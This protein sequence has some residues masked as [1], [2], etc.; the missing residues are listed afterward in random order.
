MEK[1]KNLEELM[2]EV[3]RLRRFVLTNFSS[4]DKLHMEFHRKLSPL[5]ENYSIERLS[6]VNF[7][8]RAGG[9][10]TVEV[11]IIIPVYGKLSYTLGCL[12][13]LFDLGTKYSYEIIVVDDCSDDDSFSVLSSISGLRVIQNKVNLG[14]LKSCNLAADE[15]KGKYLVFLNNDT[16]VLSGWLDHLIDTFDNHSSVGLVGSQL[17]YPDGRL[18]EAGGILWDDASGWNYGRLDDPGKPEYSYVRDVDYCSGASIA[19]RKE[20]FLEMGGFDEI[21][22][23]AYFEDADLAFE[24]NKAGYRVLYQPMSKVIHFEGITSGRDLSSGVKSFQVVNKDKFYRKWRDRLKTHRKHGQLPFLERDRECKG[25]VLV[26][27]ALTPTPDRDAGSVTAFFYLKILVEMGYKVTFVPESLVSYGG[28]TSALQQI[29]VECLYQPSL[30]TVRTYLQNFGEHFDVVFLYRVWTARKF[31]DDVKQL[32]PNAKI[33]FDTVDLHYLREERKAELS[34]DLID[35][36]QA[37][38]T[39]AAEYFLMKNADATIVLSEE[40]KRIVEKSDPSIVPYVIPLILDMPGRSQGFDQR[41]GFMFIGGYDHVPNVDAVEYFVNQ[42]W[43]LVRKLKPDAQF[44]IVGSRAP[45]RVINLQSV[46]GVTYVGFVAD[47]AEC[48]ERV[49]VNIVP[50]RYGAGIKGKIGSASSYG[51]PTVATSIAVEGMGMQD[52]DN[53]IIADTPLV[54]A[55]K[56][57]EMHDNPELWQS[58]S[59]ATYQ[60]VEQRYS[61][62]KGRQRLYDLLENLERA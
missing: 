57:V 4:S 54:F 29:G 30:G 8:E 40:E 21:Y 44:F 25:R 14:F 61:E 17:L 56:M 34:G 55:R 47:L 23:P 15:A 45:E 37:S 16:E 1:N 39:K 52:G 27:D 26:I 48:F 59:D 38:K 41:N 31:W 22:S 33:I 32:C 28:Y 9:A 20:L 24:V 49:R 50:L 36:A 11:S 7:D 6:D 51:V 3:S 53:I 58:I 13:S 12:V 42:I 46:E 5:I 60:F 19:I 43:P 35:S 18:Q 2:L 10:G 62:A